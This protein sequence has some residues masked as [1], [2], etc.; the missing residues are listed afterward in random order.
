MTALT[1]EE[2]F[3]SVRS[4]DMPAFDTL[5][6]R[7]ESPLLG[8]IRGMLTNVEESE[9]VFH[10]SFMAVLKSRDVAFD[11]ASFKTWLYQIARNKCLNRR[12]SWWRGG[13]AI[14]S[15]RLLE[16]T[17]LSTPEEMLENKRRTENLSDAVSELSTPLLEMYHLRAAGM[18]YDEMARVLEIPLGTVKTRMHD[19]IHRLRE[20]MAV[21][22]LNEVK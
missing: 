5:Y 16:T 15:L 7:F 21:W 18:S 1:D 19:L 22:T 17:P 2:L 13:K 9:D 10:E 11:R 3:K 14:Q 8:F 6:A 20:E 12:R 4:G